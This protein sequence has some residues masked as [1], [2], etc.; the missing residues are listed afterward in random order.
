MTTPPDPSYDLARALAAEAAS[1]GR[2]WQTLG[3]LTR[4]GASVKV[5]HRTCGENALSILRHGF[6]DATGRF[7]TEREWSGV[8][9]SAEHPL[10]EGDADLDVVLVV[11]LPSDVF[12][13]W[14]W[15]EEGKPYREALIPA[16]ELNAAPLVEVW[17]GAEAAEAPE[18]ADAAL[19]PREA[20]ARLEK[21][22]SRER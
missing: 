20:L 3:R 4:G 11:E 13:T 21:A 15:R 22:S 17:L 8:F 7:L 16:S 12:E 2:R 14:E 6:K 5:Y 1:R 18:E 19:D 9:V 10:D